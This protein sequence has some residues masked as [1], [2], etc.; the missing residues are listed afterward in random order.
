MSKEQNTPTDSSS[1]PLVD[2][3]SL[4]HQQQQHVAHQQQQ[5]EHK[6]GAT[7]T[8]H[9]KLSSPPNT[10]ISTSSNNVNGVNIIDHLSI[11]KSVNH[12]RIGDCI[13]LYIDVKSGDSIAGF[14]SV[15]GVN[16]NCSENVKG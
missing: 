13:S 8:T 3:V 9:Q 4:F 6:E 5:H 15:D 7:D 2:Y 11:D 16:L 14:L 10:T 1:S 12:L